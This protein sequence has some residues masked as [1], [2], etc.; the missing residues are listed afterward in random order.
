MTRFEPT[1]GLPSA[2]WLP[3][4]VAA[5]LTVA[6]A[7]R[8]PAALDLP[9]APD[10]PDAVL[11][12]SDGLDGSLDVP[13]APDGSLDVPA[14]PDAVLDVGPVYPL[15]PPGPGFHR[16]GAAVV[17]SMGRTLGLHGS[18]VSNTAKYAPDLLTW[19]GP[20]DFARLAEVGF[21]H[22]RLLTF[23][24]A[25]MPQPGVLDEAYLD[26]FALRVAWAA[27]AGLL[28][29][30][31]L[32]Q[33]V[34]GVGF[35][36]DGAPRWACDE[37]HYAAYQPT[38]PWFLNYLSP[39]VQACYDGFWSDDALF[40]RY[41]DAW[42]AL[43]LRLADQPAVLGFD[44]FNE[45]NWGSLA[46][47]AWVS[48][49]YQPRM[50]Q[51]AAALR[52]VAPDRLIF[53]Q[54]TQLSSI[55]HVDPFVPFAD[56]RTVFAPHYYHPLVHDGGAYDRATMQPQ[57]EATLDKI[58][59]MAGLLGGLPLWLGEMG[60]P[61]ETP[62]FDL[63]LADL[64]T[65]L[66]R[67]GWGFAQYDDAPSGSFALRTAPGVFRDGFARLV[68]H[69]YARRVPGPVLE[70]TLDLP[71]RT[72]VTRFRWVHDAPLEVWTGYEPAP[73]GAP[74][75]TLTRDEAPD[76]AALACA[77][78]EGAPRGVWACPAEGVVFGSTYRLALTAP[79]ASEPTPLRR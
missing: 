35:G 45:P 18:S 20:A 19:H 30:V 73:A 51:L 55:N 40:Q 57:M 38:T 66:A 8:G 50:E 32:H 7:S 9:D 79:A 71:L 12:V 41:V 72:F 47:N 5:L 28:V 34:F 63:Y 16:V 70:S 74:T 44:L 53:L 2:A 60:G 52:A 21:D 6:C 15:P 59:S 37:A 61:W 22:V 42:V 56:P 43:A 11:D 62:G 27:E 49:V 13:D 48:T 3:W 76:D 39:E 68:G 67:R 14:V 10:A 4:L 36:E 29:V 58:A 78:V 25:V 24:A 31:D 77:P 75:V 17:D 23:W 33:D 46:V 1:P 69:P 26:A 64:L 54:G 65:T